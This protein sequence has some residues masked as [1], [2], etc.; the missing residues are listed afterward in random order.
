MSGPTLQRKVTITNPLGFH[1]RPMAAF[2]R[3]AA[4][5]QSTV[6]L[7]NG[8]RRVNGKSTLELMLL[9]AEQGTE[10]LLEIAGSDAADALEPLSAILAAP[11]VDDEP[12]EPVPPKG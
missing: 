10:I 8:E 9:A 7:S 12:E 3:L 6:T 5:Y 1:L 4:Q 11:A 2:A